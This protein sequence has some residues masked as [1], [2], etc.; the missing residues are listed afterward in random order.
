MSRHILSMWTV[1]ECPVDYPTGY[2]AR[3]CEI[4]SGGRIVNTPELRIG[5]SLDEVR[6]QLPPGLHCIPRRDDDHPII[7]EVWV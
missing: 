7:V 3:R 6:A 2:V 1:Y 5:A 4:H